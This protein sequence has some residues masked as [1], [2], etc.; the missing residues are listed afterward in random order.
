MS[1]L[2]NGWEA[3]RGDPWLFP[4]ISNTLKPWTGAPLCEHAE[5]SP[6]SESILAVEA[7]GAGSEPGNAWAG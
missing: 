4:F 1:S 6:D 7:V 2:A 3:A 5:E